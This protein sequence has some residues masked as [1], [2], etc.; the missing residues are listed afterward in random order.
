MCGVLG[1]MLATS[2]IYNIFKKSLLL[3]ILKHPPK[4][5]V[6]YIGVRHQQWNLALKSLCSRLNT[7]VLS[8]PA[9]TGKFIHNY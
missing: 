2:M 3:R 1:F 4:A 6:G 8:L 7:Y 9:I 5:R